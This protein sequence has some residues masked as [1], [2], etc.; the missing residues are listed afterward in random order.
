V[1]VS[2]RNIA[3][4]PVFID[5]GVTLKSVTTGAGDVALAVTSVLTVTP[6]F[7]VSITVAVSAPPMFEAIKT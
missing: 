5:E 3:E 4:S 6:G 1:V 7:T 2:H